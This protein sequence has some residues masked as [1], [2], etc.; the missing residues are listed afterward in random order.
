MQFLLVFLLPLFSSPWNWVYRAQS[1]NIWFRI[2]A[3]WHYFQQLPA[4]CRL[5]GT[6]K[7]KARS[8]ALGS[9]L[10]YWVLSSSKL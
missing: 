5:R 2:P 9:F 7:T 10:Q 8:D 4:S 3:S 1:R 6:A